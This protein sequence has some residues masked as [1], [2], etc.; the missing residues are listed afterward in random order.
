MAGSITL[1]FNDNGTVTW[2][3]GSGGSGGKGKYVWL[4]EPE[5]PEHGR[6]EYVPAGTRKDQSTYK[7]FWTCTDDDCLNR[8]G[9]GFTDSIN[10]EEYM[11]ES[12]DDSES[13]D[14]LPF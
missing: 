12:A 8:P 14:S 13:M 4:D 1:Q 7:A 3:R 6:W 9:R 10:P 5:C 11:S 2:T